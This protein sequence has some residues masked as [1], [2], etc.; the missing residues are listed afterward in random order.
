VLQ[1]VFGVNPHIEDVCAR[2]AAQGW[3]AVSPHLYHRDGLASIEYDDVQTALGHLGHLERD[4]ILEDLDAAAEYIGEEGIPLRKIGA[5]GFCMGCTVS[6]DMA[7]E[8]DIGAAVTFYGGGIRTGRFGFAPMAETAPKL[9]VP[10]LGI[11]GDLDHNI[12]IEEVEELRAAAASSGHPTDVIRYAD[13]DHGFHCDVRASYN[14]AAARD[15]WSRTL[16]WFGS[17]LG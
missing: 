16:A 14:E 9:R 3:L 7:V 4:G 6:F 2:F 8:R 13:A 11:F 15:G 5:V 10:W 1:E 12:P 17:L